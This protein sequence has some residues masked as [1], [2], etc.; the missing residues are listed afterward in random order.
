MKY[1]YKKPHFFSFSGRMTAAEFWS[2]FCTSLIGSFCM[3]IALCIVLSVSTPGDDVGDLERIMEWI[4]IA[5]SLFW[6]THIVALT[7][8]RLRDAGFTA[9]SYL[10]LLLPVVG[11]FI[12]IFTRLCARSVDENTL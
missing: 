7:R 3:L 1:M 6:L 2:S 11:W 10:W 4:A 5:N 9:K 12:F 8:R